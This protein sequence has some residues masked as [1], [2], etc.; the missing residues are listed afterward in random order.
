MKAK[1]LLSI[2]SSNSTDLLFCEENNIEMDNMLKKNEYKDLGKLCYCLHQNGASLVAFE[3]YF[4]GYTIPQISNE[5][6]LLRFS[7][8]KII[9]IE[10]KSELNL[11]EEQK[12]DKI[13]KQLEKN[14]YYLKFL[15]KEIVCYTFV[16]GDGLYKYEHQSGNVFKIEPL[17]MINDLNSQS[18]GL[19]TTLDFDALF[20]PKN[21]LVSPFN[22]T[23]RFINGEYFLT[24]AQHNIKSEIFKLLEQMVN[25]KFCL[26]ANAGTGKT[27]LVYDIAKTLISEK[28]K[29]LIVHC[30]ILNQ[31]HIDLM[32]KYHWEI[33]PIKS[34]ETHIDMQSNENYDLII[35]DESQRIKTDQLD[36]IVEECEKRKI[37][38]LFSYDVK[39]YLRKNEAVDIHQYLCDN[40]NTNI[41]KAQLTNKIR[42][43][44]EIS[45]FITNLF[46]IGKSNAFM[47][48][49]NITIDYF[50][51]KNVVKQ[52]I[53]MLESKGYKSIGFTVSRYSRESLDALNNICY[54][55]AHSVIGQEFE[56]VVFVMDDNFKYGEN[57]KLMA[58]RNYYDARGMLFQIVTRAVSELKIV[59]LNNEELYVNLMKIKYNKFQEK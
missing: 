56:K 6:D 38:L 13:R 34:M 7:E 14:Y 11:P 54:S 35:F 53:E 8:D 15:E 48:Y 37:P 21:Y 4:L 52:Y 42:T 1:N 27:L 9:N 58:R 5:F 25:F 55:N 44:K 31:G 23:E 19:Q 12:T 2:C 3:G 10:L 45:S 59:V 46:N 50:K 22:K 26:S 24:D 33:C 36:Y 57:N 47:D 30:G 20:I 17:E 40:Y 41:K 29:V 18:A 32:I 49:R 43:N 39:Q 16:S 51:D 28:K